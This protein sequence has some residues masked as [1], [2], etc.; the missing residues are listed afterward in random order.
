MYELKKKNTK[1]SIS[2]LIDVETAHDKSA[3]IFHS[4]EK[5]TFS[6]NI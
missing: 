3:N 1:I 5:K 6:I 2:F 4:T